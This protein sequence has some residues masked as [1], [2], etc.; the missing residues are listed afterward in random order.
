MA[1]YSEVIIYN[2][3]CPFFWLTECRISTHIKREHDP[4]KCTF[5]RSTG[6]RSI[7]LNGQFSL[8]KTQTLQEGSTVPLSSWD[9]PPAAASGMAGESAMSALS[10]MEAGSLSAAPPSSLP[11]KW[12]R[13]SS[14][15]TLVSPA[16]RCAGQDLKDNETVSQMR[17]AL[18]K[19]WH[20]E[21]TSGWFKPLVDIKLKVAF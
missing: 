20:T 12:L 5:V 7:H 21:D 11:W 15:T 8:D 16:S 14:S 18:G 6:T 1:Q 13:V 17:A 4:K 3:H 9:W 2:P 10:S 19:V